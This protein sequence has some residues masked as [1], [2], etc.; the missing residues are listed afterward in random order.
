MA[1]VTPEQW[2][3]LWWGAW[4]LGAAALGYFVIKWAIVAAALELAK[5]GISVVIRQ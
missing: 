4:T 2:Y 5:R 3:K 1:I